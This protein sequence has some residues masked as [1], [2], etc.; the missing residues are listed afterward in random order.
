MESEVERKSVMILLQ[1]AKNRK[2]HKL[3]INPN[4]NDWLTVKLLIGVWLW[5]RI[6]CCIQYSTAEFWQASLLFGRKSSELRW[7]L[8]EW[9]GWRYRNVHQDNGGMDMM[10]G[11][12]SEWTATG[13]SPAAIR[14]VLHSDAR[15]PKVPLSEGIFPIYQQIVQRTYL[16]RVPYVHLV[17][18][19]LFCDATDVVK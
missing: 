8:L 18:F 15:W 5:F 3:T 2:T 19:I 9:T 6:D 7:C 4:D 1:T 11:E 14:N 17:N 12:A 16:S 13:R 10:L